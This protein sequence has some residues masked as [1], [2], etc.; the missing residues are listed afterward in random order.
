MRN[1]SVV[2]ALLSTFILS[3]CSCDDGIELI[4]A[5]SHRSVKQIPCSGT[6]DDFTYESRSKSELSV[7]EC[8]A[9]IIRCRQEVYRPSDFC[10][11]D[12]DCLANWHN[13]RTDDICVGSVTPVGDVCDGKDNDCDGEIDEPY[14]ND[15]DGHLSAQATRPDGTVCGDDCDDFNASVNPSASE[16]CDGLDNNCNMHIDEDMQD[17]GLCHPEVPEGV[18]PSTLVYEDTDCV[19]ETGTLKCQGG[20]VM[21]DG[22][23]FI[24]PEPETCDGRDNNCNGFADEPG[25]VAGV[26]DSCGSSIGVCEPGYFICNSVTSDM[27][28]VDAYT[29]EQ[30]DMCDGLDND[31]DTQTD[32][33]AE[34]I[35]CTNGCPVYG[36][37]YCT[38]GEYS[39]CDAPQP[40]NEDTEPCNGEDDD[41]DG[42]IDEGQEC[43]C[44]PAEVGPNAPDCTIPEMQAAGLTCGKAKKDCVCENGDCQYG[45]CYRACDPRH[46]GNSPNTWW[47][48]C[49][50]EVCDGWDHDC[51]V[52]ENNV[53]GGH[54]VNVVCDCDPNSPIPEIARQAQENGPG[55]CEQGLCTA[56][57]QTCEYDQQLQTWRML[58]EDCG[59]VGPEEEVCDEEDN[60]CDGLTDEDLNS[61]ERVDMVFVIDITGSMRDEIQDIHDAISQ[62]A[63]DFMGTEHRFALLLYPAPPSS[64]P[65]DSCDEQP[66][67]NM[68]GGLVNVNVFLNLLI[69]VLNNGLECGEEPSYDV[70]Y[71]LADVQD[72]A[73]VGWRP[74]A[75][76]YVFIFGDEMAQTW[77][78]LTEQQVAARTQT[79]DGIGGCPCLPP[80]CEQPTNN[81]EIHCFI[82]GSYNNQYDSIC[83]TYNISQINAAVLRNI[84]ADVCLP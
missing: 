75:Y 27:M 20:E 6:E 56:G 9:G 46:E 10:G 70:L 54:L 47:G 71:D 2:L 83:E 22:A 34:P 76:P 39:V 19:Y 60:D 52:G 67:Y 25:A 73:N 49:D 28:C 48:L 84:F 4:K 15:Q 5:C 68:S 80:D 29:G 24:G 41:C 33:D 37:Q 40:G 36:Y 32:E 53:N 51:D 17:L 26:G 7:G 18:E 31:C 57:S 50:E 69:Q 63:Q 78:N 11:E 30:Q 74:D 8:N 72:P 58:P 65:V 81:F 16:V 1:L 62:Y 77:R 35:L 82:D 64:A 44:D 42:L 43:Q 79:C 13:I 3:S 59:A 66:Y 45:E 14:D 61:F 38:G 12:V 21:C 55:S 23:L